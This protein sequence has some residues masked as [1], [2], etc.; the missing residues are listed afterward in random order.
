MTADKDG[1]SLERDTT[2]CCDPKVW[3]PMRVTYSRELKVKAELNRLK[4]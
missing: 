1:I 4:I 3:F 2:M